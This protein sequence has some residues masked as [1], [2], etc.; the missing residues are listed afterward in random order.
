MIYRFE[1]NL[2]ITFST[3]P[4]IDVFNMLPP[5]KWRSAPCVS[6]GEGELVSGAR[7]SATVPGNAQRVRHGC[8]G[9]GRGTGELH[10]SHDGF[11]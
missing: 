3:F 4:I 8:L 6:V 9:V 5:T 11:Q 10:I 7:R 2:S 1:V